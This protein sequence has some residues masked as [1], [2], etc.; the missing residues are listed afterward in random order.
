MEF[1]SNFAKKLVEAKDYRDA[2]NQV[3]LSRNIDWQDKNISQPKELN[4]TIKEALKGII[5]QNNYFAAETKEKAD[6]FFKDLAD[7]NSNYEFVIYIKNLGVFYVNTE[8][9][10]YARYK[11]KVPADFTK[12]LISMLRVK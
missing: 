5:K 7:N 1:K 9:Y 8:G 10:D 3:H 12:E 4:N 2:F 6:K 11:M